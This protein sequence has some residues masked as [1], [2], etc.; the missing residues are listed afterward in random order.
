MLKVMIASDGDI[1][2]LD[3]QKFR[4]D[5]GYTAVENPYDGLLYLEVMPWKE[6]TSGT[7]RL[8]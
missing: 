8:G 3:P 4:S 7:D 2:G 6:P 1:S 5:A